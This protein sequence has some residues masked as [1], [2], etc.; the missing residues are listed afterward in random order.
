MCKKKK[1]PKSEV[2]RPTTSLLK[3]I[4]T[5][6]REHGFAFWKKKKRN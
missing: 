2:V 3:Y 6:F 1:K 5:D 4:E